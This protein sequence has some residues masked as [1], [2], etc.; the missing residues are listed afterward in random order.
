[1]TRT[2]S[3]RIVVTGMGTIN[4][5]GR[6][7]DETW[8]RLLAAR[9]GIGVIRNFDPEQYGLK[10][11]IAGEVDDFKGPAFAVGQAVERLDRSTQLA[12]VAA[13]EALLSAGLTINA[14]N[15]DGVAVVMGS[16][17]GGAAS[18]HH[19]VET[20]LTRGS[21]RVSALMFPKCMGNACAAAVSLY[22]GTRGPA[23]TI[24][25]ACASATDAIG[26]AADLIR[27]GRVDIALAGGSEAA[28][29]P[30][31]MA[32]LDRMGAIT[33]RYNGSPQLASRPFDR[34]RDGFVIAEGSG[35]LILE[36][37]RHAR[38]RQAHILAE[39]AGY[40]SA[41]DA[42]HLTAPAPDGERALSVMRAALLD[43]GAGS[44]DVVHINAHGTSTRLNDAL[45]ARVISELLGERTSCTPVSATKSATGHLGGATGGLE[46]VLCV[47]SCITG[48]APPTL[49]Y[50]H[51]DAESR[52]DIVCGAAR[53]L[54]PGL[55][56]SNSFGFGGHCSCLAFRPY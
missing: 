14:A 20:L 48:L 4:A 24:N 16:A 30:V 33:S 32:S 23:F 10:T 18:L 21:R 53:A 44:E 27:A 34:D 43:A 56:L 38:G 26:V 47:K 17:L 46:A 25:S 2:T 22:S 1:M 13:H 52:L 42:Y 28:I 3:T 15:R 35:M 11:R 8:A 37:E 54:P 39:I 19:G 41:S 9:S 29:L 40:S 49:N 6:T 12:L 31:M 55:I 51:G 50:E 45:E 5:L 7:V 36:S